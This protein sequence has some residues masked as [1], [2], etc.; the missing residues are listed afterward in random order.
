MSRIIIYLNNAFYC[1][2]I[3]QNLYLGLVS[4]W[5]GGM[6]V[7]LLSHS[8][9]LPGSLWHVLSVSRGFP[10][11]SPVSSYFPKTC[12]NR[13]V[14]ARVWSDQHPAQGVFRC[15][16][17]GSRSTITWIKGLLKMNERFNTF[18]NHANQSLLEGACDMSDNNLHTEYCFMFVSGNCKKKK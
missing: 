11:S 8:S 12:R 17:I 3:N 7:V 15:S 13:C 14:W 18:N 9:R 2:S 6:V 1:I 16:G 5:K 4:L 10:L